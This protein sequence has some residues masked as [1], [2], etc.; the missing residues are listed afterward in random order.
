MSERAG[1][2]AP[3]FAT[4]VAEAQRQ[5]AQSFTRAGLHPDAYRHVSEAHA[6]ALAVP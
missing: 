6:A 5:L 4:Q 2:P 3:D 1:R